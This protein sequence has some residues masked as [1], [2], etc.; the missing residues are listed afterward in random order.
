MPPARLRK[1]APILTALFHSHPRD[2]K[3]ILQH[4]DNRIIECLCRCCFNILKGNVPLSSYELKR[5][6]RYKKLLHKLVDRKHSTAKKRSILVQSGGLPL[7]LLA[8]LFTIA[9][10]A[11][12]KNLR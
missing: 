4:G 6:R 10:S 7:A 5:L 2:R 9:A 11:L 12:L 8:P 3:V 1:D